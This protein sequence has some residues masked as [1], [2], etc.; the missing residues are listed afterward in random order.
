MFGLGTT[1]ILIIVVIA[2][3]IFGASRLPKIGR[4]VGQAV[5]EFRDV[6]E[7]MEDA[8]KF[9]R[10]KKKPAPNDDAKDA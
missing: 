8:I 4:G 9:D 7:E 3:F 1:E 10:P 5:R 2:L 6:Q